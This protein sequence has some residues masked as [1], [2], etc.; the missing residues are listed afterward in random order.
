IPRQR[1]DFTPRAT[2]SLGTDTTGS[3]RADGF[4]Q[5]YQR[6]ALRSKH[7][8]GQEE[9]SDFCLGTLQSTALQGT[10]ESLLFLPVRPTLRKGRRSLRRRGYVGL[11]A[12]RIWANARLTH[13]LADHE[14]GAF[15]QDLPLTEMTPFAEPTHT[16]KRSYPSFDY[17]SP[18]AQFRLS[19]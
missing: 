14:T 19:R 11:W 8:S 3:Y 18:I 6:N 13:E 1:N 16:K 10:G 7:A 9:Q 2:I 17:I 12:S 5:R 15:H 4:S